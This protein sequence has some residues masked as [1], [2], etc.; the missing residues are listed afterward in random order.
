MPSPRKPESPHRLS[1][2]LGP[3]F[4]AQSSGYGVLAIFLGIVGY[5]I[6]RAVGFW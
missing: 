5:G 2:K 1:F 4:E 3:W 6:G